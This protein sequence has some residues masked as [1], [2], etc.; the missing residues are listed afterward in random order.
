MCK[1]EP[2]KR[3]GKKSTNQYEQFIAFTSLD[4]L[5]ARAYS[6]RSVRASC[7]SANNKKKVLTLH[8]VNRPQPASLRVEP[9]TQNIQTLL[10]DFDPCT[11]GSF[12]VEL[13]KKKKHVMFWTRLAG[14]FLSSKVGRQGAVT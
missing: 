5:D 2:K 9:N 6:R 11:G 1:R 8:A 12:L 7:A 4:K 3:K 10:A 14:V 13:K